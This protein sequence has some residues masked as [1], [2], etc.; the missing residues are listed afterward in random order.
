MVK[1]QSDVYTPRDAQTHKHTHTHTLAQLHSYIATPLHSYKPA[2]LHQHLDLQTHK[3]RL[4][5]AKHGTSLEKQISHNP[6]PKKPFRVE[7]LSR[8]HPLESP[9]LLCGLLKGFSGIYQP[10]ATIC[11][12]RNWTNSYNPAQIIVYIY[13]YMYVY[14]YMFFHEA[15]FP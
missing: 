5:H 14:I 8:A 6:G 7:L 12:N 4:L 3:Q 1:A 9:C 13:I 2:H 10:Q 11:N 15:R